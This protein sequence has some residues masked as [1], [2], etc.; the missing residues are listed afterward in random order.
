MKL[1][2]P[3]GLTPESFRTALRRFR[4]MLGTEAVLATDEDRETYL[5]AFAIGNGLNHAPSAALTPKSTEQVQAA[6]RIAN[7]FRVPLWPI[8]RGKNLAYGGSAPRMPGTVVLDLSRMQRILEVNSELAY[9][10]VE[11]G[12]GR[13]HPVSVADIAGGCVS[14]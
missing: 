13:T 7:E 3:P 10:R 6:V 8:S 14:D 1:I 2:L 4:D 12:V 11:P 5:D 9:C